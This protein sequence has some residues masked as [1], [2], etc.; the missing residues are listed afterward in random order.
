MRRLFTLSGIATEQIEVKQEKIELVSC[1]LREMMCNVHLSAINN[2]YTE[3]EQHRK[4]KDFSRAIDTL[5]STFYK[6]TEL[7][8]H[9][10]TKCVHHYRSNIIDSLE[11]IHDDLEKITSG[12]FGDKRHQPIYLKAINA[13]KEF[14]N[15]KLSNKFQLNESKDRFLGNHLN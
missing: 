5:K 15:V 4:T 11:I 2:G 1:P 7:M 10:C 6:T 3:A 13:L 12:I 14:E 8:D 9:P